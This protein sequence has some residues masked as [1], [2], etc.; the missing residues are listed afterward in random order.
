MWLMTKYGFYSIVQKL[1]NEFHVRS[2][3]R[4]DLQNLID[5]IPLSGC[6]ISESKSTDYLARIIVDLNMVLKILQFIGST[7]DYDNFKQRIA[8]TPDQAHKPY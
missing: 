6:L 3:E 5:N 7:L 2:R 8:E 4:R 1:P